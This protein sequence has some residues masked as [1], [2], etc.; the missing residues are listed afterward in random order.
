[1]IIMWTDFAFFFLQAIISTE[2]KIHGSHGT[3]ESAE[4][5]ITIYGAYAGKSM[6]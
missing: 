1:M 3:G 5:R 4:R 6:S 2:K